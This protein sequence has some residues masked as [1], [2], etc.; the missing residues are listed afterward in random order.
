[1]LDNGD[2]SRARLF[3]CLVIPLVQVRS[4]QDDGISKPTLVCRVAN[5]ALL[6]FCSLV[7]A[8][9]F[10]ADL[11][12]SG[13]GTIGYSRSNQA[14]TY[15]RFIDD[16]GTFRRDSVI[17]LQADAQFG[18]GLGATMQIKGAPSS[19]DDDKYQASVAWAFVSY[20]PSNDWLIRVGRQRMPLYL[21]SANF[22]VGVTH[23]FA[24]L[25]TE[26]YSISPNNEIDGV[27]FS[28]SWQLERG[29]TTLDAF[30]GRTN[31]DVRLWARDNIPPIQSPGTMFR[32]LSIE[33]GGLAL[34]RKR[35]D[36]TYRFAYG[37]V[38]VNR[39]DGN[40]IPVTF[41][42]VNTPL[43]GVGYY[44]VDGS[45]PGPGVPGVGR[46]RISSIILGA[47]VDVGSGF[48]VVGEF[49]RTLVSKT[50]LSTQSV[51]GYASLLKRVDQ[52]TPYVTFAFLRS[53]SRPLDLYKNVN[54]TVVPGFVP[55]ASLINAAQ[56]IGADQVLAFDQ[57]SLAIGTSYSL[58]ATSKLKA[59]LMHV[60]IGQVSSLV[61][62][63]PGSNI[64]NQ[65]INVISLSYSVVF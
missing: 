65:G 52:W 29:E 30:W 4:C 47:D 39:R 34:S 31:A 40:A 62:A 14:F 12:L 11:S 43:P 38:M 23:E 56:R 25:P 26:M 10:A 49:A 27:S 32:R 17:G 18:N 41:P 9:S 20:R 5:W 1:M 3:G 8:P 61:D 64:R 58:S 36:D 22:D 59:E 48:R 51:R 24:R 6:F 60:R 16:A 57:R 46:I 50:D 42:F 15:D 13:F 54:S 45:I 33:G 37:S 53:D 44:Q 21:H 63:P 19:V 2:C 28:R 35:D 55:G 7:S